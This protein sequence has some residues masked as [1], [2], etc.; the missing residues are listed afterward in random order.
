MAVF[1][2][3][4]A[5]YVKS[6]KSAWIGFLVLNVPY[7]VPSFGKIVGAVSEKLPLRT[8]GRTNGGDSI[9]PFG[10]QPGTKNIAKYFGFILKMTPKN[11][12][13]SIFFSE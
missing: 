11:H 8:D 3:N 10:F 4:Y 9:G 6:Q 2:Q 12:T 5:N 7:F 13:H 1:G